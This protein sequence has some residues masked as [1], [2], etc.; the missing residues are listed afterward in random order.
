MS[1]AAETNALVS[2]KTSD[3]QAIGHWSH[4]QDADPEVKK[5][6]DRIEKASKDHRAHSVVEPKF[7]PA[8]QASSVPS[9]ASTG[10]G[11]HSER[12]VGSS[13]GSR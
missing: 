2:R 1:A 11:P 5:V 3:F 10:L 9:N 12:A 6:L 13:C 4:L 7:E 8:Q